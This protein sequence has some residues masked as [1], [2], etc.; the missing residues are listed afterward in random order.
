MKKRVCLVAWCVLTGVAAGDDAPRREEAGGALTAEPMVVTARGYETAAALTPGSV[1]VVD[2]D[3]AALRPAVSASDLLRLISGVTAVSDGAWGSEVNIRGLSRESVVLLIDGVRVNTATD[4]AARFGTVD[5]MAIER[6][7][8][9][10]GPISSLYGSGSI[11]GVVNIVTRQGRF[12][13]RPA[14]YTGFSVRVGDNPSGYDSF[15]HARIEDARSHLFASQS[16][17]DRSSYT[18][19][20]GSKV[21]NSQFQDRESRLRGA[22]RAGEAWTFDANLQHFEGRDIGIPGS[23]AAPLPAVSTVTYPRTSRSMVKLGGALEGDGDIMDEFRMDVY[24]QRIER[25]VRIDGLPPASPVERLHP[26]ADHETIGTQWTGRGGQGAHAVTMGV[27]AWQRA[28]TSSRRRVFRSGAVAHEKPLPDVTY[29]SAGLFAENVWTVSP[30]ATLS[31]GGRWDRIQVENDPTPQWERQRRDESSWNAHLGGVAN[32]SDR[33][34]V[35]AV[36]A[37]GYRAA[38]L[39]ERY[40]FLELGAGRV[41]LGDPDLNPERSL[42]FE[43][44]ADARGESVSMGWAVFANRLRDLIG[45][46]FVDDSTIVNANVDEALIWGAEWDAAWT[47]IP[48]WTLRLSAAYA[49]GRDLDARQPLPGI[50]PLSGTVALE[51]DAARRYR[52]RAETVFAADQRK[53]PDGVADADGWATANA[54]LS[55]RFSSGAANGDLTLTVNNI[56]DSAYR[57]YLSTYRGAHYMEPGRSVT[58]Q[59]RFDL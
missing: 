17:R 1:G 49:E 21:E 57:A 4:I 24:W 30:Q 45:E 19:G 56:F 52:G 22:W 18:D 51:Y 5:P 58:V 33:A 37:S 27:D 10:K 32:V 29:L 26:Q 38:S 2:L 55:R 11:G 23:G 59:V 39:E 54:S 8:V 28:M 16:W 50:P 35:R 43:A 15:L 12:S 25:R 48:A 34:R 7:E 53:T 46:R 14:R 44:G 42:F 13:E 9:L 47:P 20:T 41:K 36:A 3:T 40:Q 6:V 31:M